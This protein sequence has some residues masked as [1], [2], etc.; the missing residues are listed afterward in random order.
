MALNDEI[1]AQLGDPG[2]ERI[3]AI[4]GTDSVRA[5][6]VVEASL[7]TILDGMARNADRAEGAR[8]LRNAL[9]QHIARDPF[10]QDVGAL[11]QDGHCILGHVLGL[12][13]QEQAVGISR[14]AGLSAGSVMQIMATLAPMVMSL[15]AERLPRQDMDPPTLAGE[16]DRERALLPTSPNDLSTPRER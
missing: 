5:R 8:E 9:D 2:L 7:G 12:Q 1:F 3:A 15:L 14:F 16:L 11:E 4:L 10:N 13:G 6:E